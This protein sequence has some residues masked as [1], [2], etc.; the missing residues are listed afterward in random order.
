L[1]HRERHV[2]ELAGAIGLSQ[3]CTTRHLQ[4]LA[5]ERVVNTRRAGKR[6]IVTLALEV[7]EVERM[8]RLLQAA[9]A[10]ADG[11]AGPAATADGHREPSLEPAGVADESREQTHARPGTS[12]TPAPNPA[13]I[14]ERVP[15]RPLDLEDFLL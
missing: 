8:V 9:G 2:S 10:A 5:R 7:P 12:G 3:S 13:G 4:A 1:L 14:P 6:V 11:S 15:T